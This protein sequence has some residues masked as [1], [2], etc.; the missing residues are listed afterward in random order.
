MQRGLRPVTLFPDEQ[1]DDIETYLNEQFVNEELED[2][3]MTPE[4]AG[5][6]S[7]WKE[8]FGRDD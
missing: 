3:N 2:G 5:F 6:I 4:E 8:A 7:G 1:V